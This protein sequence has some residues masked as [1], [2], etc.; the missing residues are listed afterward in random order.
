MERE[1]ELPRIVRAR[2]YR[3]Y[4]ERGTRYVDFYQNGGRALLGHRPPGASQALK[5]TLDRGLVA[6]YPTV[7]SGRL[8]KLLKSRFRGLAEA[9][10]YPSEREAERAAGCR[11][12]DI[13][14]DEGRRR[15]EAGGGLPLWRPGALSRDEECLLLAGEWGRLF[16]PLLPFPGSFA[17]AAVCRLPEGPELP[18]A[19]PVSPVLEA[20]LVKCAA[21]LQKW[22]E[23]ADSSRWEYFDVPGL[24]R[25]GP[26][27]RLSPDGR[28]YRSLRTRLLERGVLLPP[29]ASI[30]AVIPGEYTAGEVEPLKKELEG[31]YGT[32]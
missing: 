31:L 9:R 14:F 21:A 19:A 6:E 8:E 17:P 1:N 5:S 26:Y 27:M 23:N 10:L 7:W 15:C 28:E 3:L 29:A 4:D 11:L 16:V 32:S 13:T 30:P 12:V 25:R 24:E 22:E 2:G 20:V 18:P